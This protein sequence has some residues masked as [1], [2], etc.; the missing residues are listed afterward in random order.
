MD[1]IHTAIAYEPQ[2]TYIRHVQIINEMHIFEELL[3]D[4]WNMLKQEKKLCNVTSVLTVPLL[5]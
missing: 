2:V 1:F 4:V 3:R 5:V